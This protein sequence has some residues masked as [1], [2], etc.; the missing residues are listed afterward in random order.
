MTMVG[1]FRRSLLFVKNFRQNLALHI[2]LLYHAFMRENRELRLRS[3]QIGNPVKLSDT[4][5]LKVMTQIYQLPPEEL[6]KDEGLEV[7][8]FLR[9]VNEEIGFRCRKGTVG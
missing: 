4:D 1:F 3:I 5:L 8:C 9:K 2:K 6:L 7:R